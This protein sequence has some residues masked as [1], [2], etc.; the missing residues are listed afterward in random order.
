MFLKSEKNKDGKSDGF[1]LTVVGAQWGD[2]GKGKIV[3]TLA[4]QSDLVVRFQGGHNAGHTVVWSGKKFKMHLLPSGVVAGK[5]S[6]IAAGVVVDP[7]ALKREVC[8]LRAQGVVVNPKT[9]GI[10]LRAAVIMPWHAALDEAREARGAVF[11]AAI[12]NAKRSTQGV[13]GT[14]KRGIGP[15]YEDRAARF[16]LVFADLLDANALKEK[17]FAL[18]HYKQRLL[19]SMHC[20]LAESPQ[21]IYTEYATLGREFAA[22][23]CDAASE[24]ASAVRNGKRVLFEGAQGTFLDVAFGTYPF[25]TSSS[26]I[27][28]GACVGAGVPPS[29]I[30]RVEGVAK[31][32]TTRVGNGPFPTELFDD[33][34]A[35]LQR[36]GV[37]FGTSTGRSRRCGWLDAT[38]LRR[39]NAL[40]GFDGLHLTKLDVLDGLKEIKIAVALEVGGRTLKE[41]PILARDAQRAKP[42]YETLRGFKRVNWK[43]VVRDGRKKGF[44][45]LPPAAL[46]FVRRIEAL[47]GVPIL[48]VSVGERREDIVFANR[49][50]RVYS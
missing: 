3:H 38:M 17:V 50:S 39:A 46:A 36:K 16:G 1:G 13:I 48:S 33:V 32:Y 19:H 11:G 30:T 26:T 14:T 40:N 27:A 2:E 31:A 5:R 28:G 20:G 37:E 22:F 45:A 9:L 7:R 24:A 12:A 35:H 25:V 10:D 15:A 18:H 8:E 4:E 41:F 47:V 23:A 49:H 6:L 42:V 29:A 21:K 44:D 34:G 43:R